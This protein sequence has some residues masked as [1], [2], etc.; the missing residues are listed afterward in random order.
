[1]SKTKRSILWFRQDLRIHDNEALKEALEQSVE[2]IPVYVFDPRVVSGKTR[3]FDLPKTGPFRMRFI[4]ESLKDLRSSLRSL[5]SDLVIRIGYP[6][7][8]LFQLAHTYKTS[9]IFCNRERTQEE[10]EVQDALEKELWSIGQ[11]IRYSRGKMLYYTADL[12]FPVTQTPDVFAHF[13]KEVER[14]IEIREPLPVPD[15]L[16]MLPEGL[17]PG[18]I[19]SLNDLGFEELDQLGEGQM[20]FRGGEKAG[21]QRLRYY[22]WESNSAKTYKGNTK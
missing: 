1:M 22:L 3:W 20:E 7:E 19:P 18:K 15:K 9:W 8:E 6:E 2:V 4:L 16:P 21:L 12:P 13:K 10:L 17:D 11:E 5:G 14:Y